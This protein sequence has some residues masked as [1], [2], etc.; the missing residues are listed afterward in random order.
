MNMMAMISIYWFVFY[1]C[2]WLR[3]TLWGN[4]LL[5]VQQTASSTKQITEFYNFLFSFHYCF[6]L[7]LFTSY[8][9]LS[10]IFVLFCTLSKE[11][12]AEENTLKK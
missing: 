6:L 5:P 12:T 7:K 2:K 1:V 3:N 11:K 9:S 8:V 4:S 10:S